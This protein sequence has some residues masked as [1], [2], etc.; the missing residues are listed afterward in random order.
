MSIKRT[1]NLLGKS[2]TGIENLGVFVGAILIWVI[3]ILVAMQIAMREILFMGVSWIDELARY[4]HIVM[5]CL[6]LAYI[7]RK[8]A[9]VDIR[10]FV[11]LLP[12]AAQRI[13][14]PITPIVVLCSSV[15]IVWGSINLIQRA[16][17]SRLPALGLEVRYFLLPTAVGFGLL[18][19][20]ALRQL[21]SYIWFSTEADTLSS[22]GKGTGE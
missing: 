2:L 22:S 1:A 8:G 3:V 11:D 15:F 12:R 7:L 21:V 19:I 6:G 17:A 20:R 10:L 4:L 9:D 13:L 5:I 16:G 18:A 14:R